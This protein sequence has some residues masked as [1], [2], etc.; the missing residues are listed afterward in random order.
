MGFTYHSPA[1]RLKSRRQQR[2]KKR[3][4]KLL[5]PLAIHRDDGSP[6]VAVKDE[7][8]HLFKVPGPL[9]QSKSAPLLRP[10]NKSRDVEHLREYYHLRVQRTL[11]P[12]V[13]SMILTGAQDVEGYI[14][15]TFAQA[16]PQLTEAV[17]KIQNAKQ[18]LKEKRQRTRELEAELA[19]TQARIK[20]AAQR[21]NERVERVAKAQERRRFLRKQE[22]V[23]ERSRVAAERMAK[24]DPFACGVGAVRVDAGATTFLERYTVRP[25]RLQYR[26]PELRVD[27]S[28]TSFM[29][30]YVLKREFPP[31]AYVPK[32]KKAPNPMAEAEAFVV[33]LGET[34]IHV[35]LLEFVARKR[36]ELASELELLKVRAAGLS[37]Q[38]QHTAELRGMVQE[39]QTDLLFAN[40]ARK[41]RLRHE[42]EKRQQKRGELDDLASRRPDLADKIDDIL[43]RDNGLAEMKAKTEAMRKQINEV[44]EKMSNALRRRNLRLQAA[45][46]RQQPEDMIKARLSDPEERQRVL[47]VIMAERPDL[48]DKAYALVSKDISLAE[49][50]AQST[51]LRQ[52]VQSA[53]A[54][55]EANSPKSG[56][57][58]VTPTSPLTSSRREGGRSPGRPPPAHTAASG[59]ARRRMSDAIGPDQRKALQ[60][61]AGRRPELAEQINAVLTQDDKLNAMR[62][63]T[64]KL[65]I[66]VENAQHNLA[67]AM[68]KGPA[69]VLGL[70]SGL[71][72]SPSAGDAS[73]SQPGDSR[74][75]H[76]AQA[77]VAHYP[78]SPQKRQELMGLIAKRPDLAA[79]IHGLLTKEKALVQKKEDVASL[80]QQVC[81]ATAALDIATVRREQRI[82]RAN[83]EQPRDEAVLKKRMELE[84]L[85]AKRPDLAAKIDLI[86]SR[87]DV[88]YQA[89]SQSDELKKEMER[90]KARM[91]AAEKRRNERIA[92]SEAVACA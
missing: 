60:D 7:R 58:P 51:A 50:K 56:T 23:A 79:Q 52:Q 90:V 12:I 89:R 45:R 61:L 38:A 33:E 86:L 76:N 29:E 13:E 53:Q 44:S 42:E 63:A 65:S 67:R 64:S 66:Q 87:E 18:S 14:L 55:I 24:K 11:A 78:P 27:A 35:A 16:L 5:A 85:A 82:K 15:R 88:L 17:D 91:D 37:D 28:K 39:A 92:R 21:R 81:E 46:D 75:E 22:E 30:R 9:S 57:S 80:K 48:A 73:P 40:D 84:A 2:R 68:K 43:A 31:E 36:P 6:K 34:D 47:E 20:I 71:G 10:L 19:E 1:K 26:D 32:P 69:G 77:E 72:R 62:V 74:A 41:K 4:V 83:G 49:M 70:G 59:Q 25:P 8:P 54:K 3:H